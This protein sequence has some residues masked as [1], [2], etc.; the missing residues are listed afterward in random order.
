LAL[1]HLNYPS[2]ATCLGLLTT[3]S[4]A[5]NPSATR[6]AFRVFLGLKI[7]NLDVLFL[8][9]CHITFPLFVRLLFGLLSRAEESLFL[10][11]T[12]WY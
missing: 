1:K 11:T 4:G 9:S 5:H 3:A 12:I 2:A 10:Q 8:L 7:A 6:A